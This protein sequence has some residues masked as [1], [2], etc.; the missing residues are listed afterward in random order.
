MHSSQPQTKDMEAWAAVRC[1][2]SGQIGL[3]DLEKA[4]KALLGLCYRDADWKPVIDAIFATEDDDQAAISAVDLF[5]KKALGT[6]DARAFDSEGDR[7]SPKPPQL[8]Q[9]EDDL[10][11]TVGDLH[12][13]RLIRVKPTLE[14]LINPSDEQ[15]DYDDSLYKFP[16]GDNDIIAAVVADESGAAESLESQGD[17]DDDEEGQEDLISPKEGA[18]VCEKLEQLALVHS[19]ASGVHALE[20]QRQLRR[21][22]AH[23]SKLVQDSLV[24]VSI[25]NFLRVEP[26]A[27]S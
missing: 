24:Q 14:D 20:L 22:R 3:P 10:M 6:A 7:A 4:L 12:N 23:L 27:A 1:F 5:E 15:L 11:T 19:D 25:E 17:E 2:A 8:L 9:L 18:S 26:T 16:G 13:R 21:L